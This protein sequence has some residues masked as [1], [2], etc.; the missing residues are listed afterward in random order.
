M[1]HFLVD[2]FLPLPDYYLESYKQH[3]PGGLV[4]RTQDDADSE[5]LDEDSLWGFERVRDL[6][7]LDGEYSIRQVSQL[8]RS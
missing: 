6:D 4:V 5:L 1:S 7:V 8:V 2:L 3:L